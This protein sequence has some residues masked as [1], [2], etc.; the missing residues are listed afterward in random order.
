MEQ[1]EKKNQAQTTYSGDLAPPAHLDDAPQGLSKT[2]KWKT[3]LCSLDDAD[4]KKIAV[5]YYGG[6]MPWKK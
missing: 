3:R 5:K 4:Q 2:A 6:K 1:I